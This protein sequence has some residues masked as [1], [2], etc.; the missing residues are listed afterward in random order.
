MRVLAPLLAVVLLFGCAANNRPLQLIGGQ[1]PVYPAAAKASGIE[2]DVTV[3]YDVGVDGSVMNARVVS[4]TQGGLFDEAAL[5]AVKSWRFNAPL[6]N[7]ERQA[8]KNREST[9][10]FRLGGADAYDGY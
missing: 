4:S 10:S 3:R 2:G 8:A 1:G 6:V 5:A 7:G 9:V